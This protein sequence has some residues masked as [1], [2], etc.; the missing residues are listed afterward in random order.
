MGLIEGMPDATILG[1][2]GID[3]AT[4]EL[5][6]NDQGRLLLVH[7]QVDTGI[8]F[9]NET[10]ELIYPNHNPDDCASLALY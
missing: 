10:D 7:I 8:F 1:K 2:T 5:R 9:N 3:G 6:T 4:P